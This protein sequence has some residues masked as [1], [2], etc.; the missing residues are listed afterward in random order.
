[1]PLITIIMH[2]AWDLA[3]GFPNQLLF[4]VLLEEHTGFGTQ[5]LSG[6]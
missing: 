6:L 4:E 5:L 3:R 2:C 1:M